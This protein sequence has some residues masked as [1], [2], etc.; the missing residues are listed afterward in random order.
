MSDIDWTPK[1]ENCV[2]ILHTP[3]QMEWLEKSAKTITPTEIIVT[4]ESLIQSL[5]HMKKIGFKLGDLPYDF[6]LE[7]LDRFKNDGWRYEPH[8]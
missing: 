1:T 5:L 7:T 4:Q 2:T 3:I 8:M 6:L